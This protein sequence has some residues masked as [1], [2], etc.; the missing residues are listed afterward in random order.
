MPTP[1]LALPLCPADRTLLSE[2]MAFRFRRDAD[3]F[4]VLMLK[5]DVEAERVDVYNEERPQ[6]CRGHFS[7]PRG[8]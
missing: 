6:D 2:A 4:A 3:L 5:P 1:V 8:Q 7:I